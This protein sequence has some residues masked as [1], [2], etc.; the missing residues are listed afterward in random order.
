MR[1]ISKSVASVTG[2]VFGKKYNMLGR[3]VTHWE[4]I[5]GE[6]VA[7]RSIPVKLN[8]RKK[9]GK[10]PE[11]V[12]EIG[13]NSSEAT[14]LSYRVDLILQRMN[15]IFGDKVITAIRFVPFV[16]N[17]SLSI[18][19]KMVKPLTDDEINIISTSLDEVEDTEIRKKLQLLGQSILQDK[20]N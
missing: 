10:K 17:E 3:I 5:V 13:A 4:D 2:K 11:F 8:Y 16:V 1:S 19:K 7:T 18:R 12:L 9:R 20:N 14:I 15:R 6:D